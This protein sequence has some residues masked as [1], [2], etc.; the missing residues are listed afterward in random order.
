MCMTFWFDATYRPHIIVTECLEERLWRDALSVVHVALGRVVA[1]Y[2]VDHD[3]NLTIIE[4]TLR[5]EPCL[6]RYC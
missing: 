5:T 2:S 4:P 1:E 3:T 6:G